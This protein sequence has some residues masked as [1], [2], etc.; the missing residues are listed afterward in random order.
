MSKKTI[1]ATVPK[2]NYFLVLPYLGGLPNKIQKQL[3]NSFQKAIPWGKINVTFKTHSRISHLFK[4]KDPIPKDI[5]SK[6]IYSYT[7]PS[8]NTR[9]IDETD[10][11]CK[12]R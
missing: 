7:C 10:R 3:Q 5:V 6:V 11:H 8:C 2:K 12:V 9:Y 4:F 1:K